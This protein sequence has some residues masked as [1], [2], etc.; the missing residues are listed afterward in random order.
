MYG[1]H[2]REL[3]PHIIGHTGS[4][5]KVLAFQFGGSSSSKLPPGGEWRCLVLANVTDV[6]LRDGPWRAGGSH[7]QQQR[8]VEDIDLDVNVH[9]RPE[10]EREQRANDS[11]E[12]GV[13]AP[14]RRAPTRESGSTPGTHAQKTSGRKPAPKTR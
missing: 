8:C 5:E 13:R 14:L 12:A 9:V 1:G 4:E 11:V 6:R 10:R 2:Y 3:C 7:R